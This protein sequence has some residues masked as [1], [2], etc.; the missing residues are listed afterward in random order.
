MGRQLSGV[1]KDKKDFESLQIVRALS[2]Q[3]AAYLQ[4]LVG[5]K[6]LVNLGEQ[7]KFNS[8][9]QEMGEWMWDL[10]GLLFLKATSY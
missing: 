6:F 4:S 3:R 1:L 10:A 7:G 9:R 5:W 8:W 2:R